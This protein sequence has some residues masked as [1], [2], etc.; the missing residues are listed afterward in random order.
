M[1]FWDQMGL[2]VSVVFILSTLSMLWKQ[3]IFLKWSIS[4][5][6]GFNI[7][8]TVLMQLSYL[9][10]N[11]YN[12]L[13][14]NKDFIWIIPVILGLLMYTRVSTKYSWIARYPTMFLLGAGLGITI[15]A[16]LR[17]QILDQIIYTVTDVANAKTSIATFNAIVIL[18]S[19]ILSILYFFFTIEHKGIYGNTMY[20]GRAVLMTSLAV[21]FAG[22]FIYSM[23]M[24]SSQLR[25]VVQDFIMR[26]ILGLP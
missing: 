17:T 14:I 7:V 18:I 5:A 21:F 10:S 1:M 8:Y 2:I 24:L 3:N 20:L 26:M 6:I 15:P 4:V 16:M 12:K 11:V 19:V 22:D 13:T 23:T 9:Q 25:I